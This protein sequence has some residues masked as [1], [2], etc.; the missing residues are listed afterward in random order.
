MR[1]S[2]TLVFA[3]AS[4]ASRCAFA[5][6][7]QS[8]YYN[9]RNVAVALDGQHAQPELDSRAYYEYSDPLVSRDVFVEWPEV[10]ARAYHDEDEYGTLVRRVPGGRPVL[11]PIQTDP[12]LRRIRLNTQQQPEAVVAPNQYQTQPSD[13]YLAQG[14]SNL[15]RQGAIRGKPQ[16][17]MDKIKGWFGKKFGKA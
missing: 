10:Q 15:Q 11:S 9:P 3:L 7:V 5:I 17:R 2:I 12:E 13:V 16:G 4:I 1:L 8:A 14:P 6:P